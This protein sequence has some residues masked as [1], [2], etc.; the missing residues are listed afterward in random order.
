MDKED[1]TSTLPPDVAISLWKQGSE[2]WNAWVLENKKYHISFEGVDFSLHV[3]DDKTVSFDGYMFPQ[4]K[5]NFKGASFGDGDVSFHGANF[6][7]GD[8]GFSLA[9]FGDGNVDFSVA[10]FGKGEV[11]FGGASFGNGDVSFSEASFGDGDVSFF[12]ASFG[13]GNVSFTVANFGNGNVSLSEASFGEGEVSFTGASFGNG[14]VSFGGASF[15]DGEVSFG[16][17]SFGDGDV[18]FS[19]AS[20]GE[21]DVKFELASFGNG[22][23]SFG[24]ASFG[25]GDVSFGE[26]SFGNEDVSFTGASFGNGNVSFGGASFGNGDVSFIIASFGDGDVSFDGASFG[27]GNVSFDRASFGDGEVSFDE[28]IFDDGIVSF[29]NAI[30]G[31]GSFSMETV[32]CQS[33]DFE[34][35]RPSDISVSPAQLLDRFSLRKATIDGPLTLNN[36]NFNC[37]PDLRS[38]K[39]SHHVDMD[40]LTVNVSLK[41]GNW[42]Q[43]WYKHVDDESAKAKL[44]RI[45]EIAEQFK[46]HQEALYFNALE[47]LA[48]RWVHERSIFKNILDIAYAKF[49]NYGLSVLRPFTALITTWICFASIYS[50]MANKFTL[51][52]ASFS[53]MLG[54]AMVNSMPFIP[55]GKNLQKEVFETYELTLI[56][57]LFL[58]MTCQSVMSLFLIF[59]IGLGLR[60]Q[61]RL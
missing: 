51:S 8:V 44:R 30:L 56:D 2:K 45:K 15:G 21:G 31:N 59:L 10:S 11:S 29:K 49:S 37:I 26:A 38:T 41:R 28:A 6:G 23:V 35:T 57:S 7:D 47:N 12:D 58:V 52:F 55:L 1:L 54:L 36:L 34:W 61:F 17:A 25:N 4:G 53:H 42:Y 50:G 33:L 60:N 18:S 3:Q 40:G 14:N 20:F 43:L 24:G 13:E 16:V 32:R 27:D 5:V 39:L 9:N 19:G 48:T 22:Y 46:H